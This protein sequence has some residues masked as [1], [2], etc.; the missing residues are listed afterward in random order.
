MIVESV[1]CIF[2]LSSADLGIFNILSDYFSLN[3]GGRILLLLS[4][5]RDCRIW[6][7]PEFFVLVLGSCAAVN[8]SGSSSV[9]ICCKQP[10]RSQSLSHKPF[11]ENINRFSSHPQYIFVKEIDITWIFTPDFPGLE[12]LK[13]RRFWLLPTNISSAQQSLI[14]GLEE[15]AIPATFILSE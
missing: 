3:T 5:C 12:G 1:L 10:I 2:E 9:S 7:V 11:I 13:D 4:S 8:K 14:R 15:E 6:I